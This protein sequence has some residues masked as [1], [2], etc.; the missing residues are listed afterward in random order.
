MENWPLFKKAHFPLKNWLFLQYFYVDLVFYA[1]FNHFSVFS[2]IYPLILVNFCCYFFKFCRNLEF[3]AWVLSYFLEAWV[4]SVLSFFQTVQKKSLIY[5]YLRR[6]FWAEGCH[7]TRPTLRWC[8]TKSTTGSDT[9]RVRPP[10][11]ICQTLTVQSS[12]AEAI[13][14]SLCGHLNEK[15]G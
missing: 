5:I 8:L 12:D 6:M 10:S 15:R 14:W 11:G 1:N 3:F 4:F 2:P 13:T 9:V 7:K